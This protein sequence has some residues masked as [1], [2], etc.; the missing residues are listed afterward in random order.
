MSASVSTA[1]GWPV[2]RS[3]G[4]I[5]LIVIVVLV[6]SPSATQCAAYGALLMAITDAARHHR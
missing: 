6:L 3:W 2:P 5:S 4:A 1:V